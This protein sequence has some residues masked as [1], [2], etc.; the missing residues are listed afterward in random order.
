MKLKTLPTRLQL[1]RSKRVKSGVER[2]TGGKWVAIKKLFELS[3]P[4]ICAECDRQGKVGNG[5]ELD[6]I[7]PLWAGGSNDFKNFQWL[8][9]YH[10][11]QKSNAE[12]SMR[13]EGIWNFE[14][15]IKNGV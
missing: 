1:S 12:L 7:V 9:I 3:N 4:R 13:K 5:D 15:V 11:R 10:H 2:I 8:C 14:N 6:H